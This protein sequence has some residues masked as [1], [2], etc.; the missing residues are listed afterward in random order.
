MS[1]S[2]R[3]VTAVVL[4]GGAGTRVGGADKGLMS[5]D[6]RRAVERVV[7]AIRPQVERVWI[8]ANRHL[9]TYRA[10]G[11]PVLVDDMPGHAGPLAG[12]ARAL[13][14]FDGAWLATLPVDAMHFPADWIARLRAALPEADARIRVAHDGVRRQ[15]LFALYPRQLGARIIAAFDGGERAVWRAQNVCG[16]VDV[17]F[18]EGEAAFPNRNEC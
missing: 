7:Q 13:R 6:G 4:A 5:V 15:A 9:D 18:A 3:G 8:S 10:L 16:C 11:L 17:P 2:A 14:E 1:V 12:I